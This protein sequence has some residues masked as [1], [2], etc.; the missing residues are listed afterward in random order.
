MCGLGDIGRRR[1]EIDCCNQ[2]RESG[3]EGRPRVDDHPLR[4]RVVK[5]NGAEE[6]GRTDRIRWSGEKEQLVLTL[7]FPEPQCHGG[8]LGGGKM[9]YFRGAES[10]VVK[11]AV[12]PG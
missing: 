8:S 6:N 2:Q 7:S 3:G 9:L 12:L 11:H 5:W 10:E 1:R 4:M